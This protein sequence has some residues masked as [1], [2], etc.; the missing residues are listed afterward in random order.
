MLML[1]LVFQIVSAQSN[2]RGPASTHLLAETLPYVEGSFSE[3]KYKAKQVKANLIFNVLDD[4]MRKVVANWELKSGNPRECSET[5]RLGISQESI[6]LLN[7]HCTRGMMYYLCKVE[8]TNQSLLGQL[9]CL[10]KYSA[11]MNSKDCQPERLAMK[12]KEKELLNLKLTEK[13]RKVL[14]D[15]LFCQ[16]ASYPLPQQLPQS[17]PGQQR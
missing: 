10:A 17:T 2:L 5:A 12:A 8:E 9:D 16:R 7:K 15:D 13:Q 3:C 1:L 4:C 6:S 11:D 14:S